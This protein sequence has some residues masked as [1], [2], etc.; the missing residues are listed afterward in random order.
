ML[1]TVIS[2]FASIALVFAVISLITPLPGGL[3]VISFS[4]ATLICVNSKAQ[5]CV[6]YIRSKYSFVNRA[7]NFIQ[8]K[9]GSKVHF[10]RDALQRTEPN[11]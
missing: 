10:I 5:S 8:R 1:N 4:L 11:E 7:L 2:I 3:I 6:R 9:I